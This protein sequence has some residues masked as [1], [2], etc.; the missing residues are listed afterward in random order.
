MNNLKLSIILPCYNVEKYISECLD[1]LYNQDISE[2]E[3]EVI[4]V[5]DCSPDS[6]RDI[7][8][9]Y[10]KKHKSLKLIDHEINKRQGGARNTG[11]R[12]AQGEYI[13]F[14]DPDDYIKTKCIKNLLS[15][16][17][18]NQ[19]DV[20]IFNFDKVSLAGEHLF[21]SQFVSDSK[22][23]T[24][25]SY[26][27]NVWDESFLNYYDGSTT[28]RLHRRLFLEENAI[29]FPEN[30]FWEDVAHS[31]RTLLFSKKIMSIS[32]SCY[33]Y[34][35]NPDSVMNK[36]L[37]FINMRVV[38]QST[39]LLGKLIIDLAEDIYKIDRKLAEKLKEGGIWRI[40]Q[41]TRLLVKSTFKE[42]VYF[43]KLLQEYKL[44]ISKLYT[45][46]NKANKFII[47]YTLI[48]KYLLF[49]INPFIQVLRKI[50]N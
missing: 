41:F 26:I 4:C 15:N 36:M 32:D 5:N 14:V 31:L 17:D 46:F 42:K 21:T 2:E 27:Y 45:N 7:I 22:V 35:T 6:T 12:A 25:I 8:V 50:K 29:M 3:Y 10:Q 20:L 28:N 43:Y 37:S 11:L 30:I 48:S 38:V 18:Q 23:F 9:A 1:S 34:R 49:L 39:I 19:L 24:G 33:F 40:N 16:C 13:W 47:R 44:V